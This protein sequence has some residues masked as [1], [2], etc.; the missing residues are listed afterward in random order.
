VTNNKF[1]S[2]ARAGYPRAFQ[3]LK[4]FLSTQPFCD[5]I[6][7][8]GQEDSI[9]TGNFEVSVGKELIL[10]KK[11]HGLACNPPTQTEIIVISEMIQ[12][13]LDDNNEEC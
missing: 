13:Y 4:E 11:C 5:Q 6:Q 12:E 1:H 9:L 7:V 8:V 3:R 2:L 10:S